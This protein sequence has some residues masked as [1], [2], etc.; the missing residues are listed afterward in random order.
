[1]NKKIT[2][3]ILPVCLLSSVFT[4]SSCNK[5]VFTGKV[6]LTYGEIRDTDYLPGDDIKEITYER[7]E[8]MIKS[9]ESFA[10]AIDGNAGCSCWVTFQRD[11]LIPYINETHARIYVIM[12][13]EFTGKSDKFGLYVEA[14]GMPA[15]SLFNKGSLAYEASYAKNSRQI[16]ESKKSF[17]EFMEQYSLLP[18]MY[19]ISENTFDS[20]VT[21]EKDFFFYATLT[22]CPDCNEVNKQFVFN[23][24]SSNTLNQNIYLLDGAKYWGDKTEKARIKA[25]MGLDAES[26]PQLGWET[27]YVPSFQVRHGGTVLDMITVYNDSRDTETGIVNSY[28]TQERLQYMPFLENDTT[29][30]NKVLNGMTL[31]A[32]EW[33]SGGNNYRAD[34]Y[35]QKY[36]N[37]IVKLFF[38]TYLK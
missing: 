31:T 21:Q 30:K 35:V 7:L 3:F 8:L 36:I 13:S 22:D 34:L 14:G 19:Y 27:G 12:S 4:I 25:K 11:C 9:K 18:K 10:L 15:I 2:K 5:D 1:M 16:F 26:D 38:E 6:Q 17:Y 29:I 33:G 37:P 20:Y 32:S 24:T 28:F 23:W